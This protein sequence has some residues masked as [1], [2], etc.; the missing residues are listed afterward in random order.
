MEKQKK[1][2]SAGNSLIIVLMQFY[3]TLSLSVKLS[4]G[5]CNC[6]DL[7]E[8]LIFPSRFG[9]YSTHSTFS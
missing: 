1:D 3:L 6:I 2:K 7:S 5:G 4:L 9:N 8:L